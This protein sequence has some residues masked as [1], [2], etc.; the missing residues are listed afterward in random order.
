MGEL[1]DRFLVFAIHF[2]RYQRRLRRN[3]QAFGS[4]IQEFLMETF[5]FSAGTFMKNNL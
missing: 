5:T 2:L 3:T 1:K 4:E